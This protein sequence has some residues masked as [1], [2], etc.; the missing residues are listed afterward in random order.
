MYPHG[1]L[2]EAVHFSFEIN[3]DDDSNDNNNGILSILCRILEVI[4]THLRSAQKSREMAA[5]LASRFVTRPDLRDEFLPQFI[6][7]CF[8]V[9]QQP[10]LITTTLTLPGLDLPFVC[11]LAVTI[12][13]FTSLVFYPFYTLIY[14][15]VNRKKIDI[16]SGR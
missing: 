12:S 8:E 13:S 6:E 11:V 1:I 14:N 5:Y 7:Y 16:I 4:K 3:V 9:R 2:D 10:L 15:I